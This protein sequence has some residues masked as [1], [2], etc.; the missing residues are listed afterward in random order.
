VFTFL[1]LPSQVVRVISIH[2]AWTLLSLQCGL[3]P[4]V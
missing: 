2:L 3:L 1:S 4:I